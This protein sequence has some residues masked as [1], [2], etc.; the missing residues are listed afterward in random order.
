MGASICV[1]LLLLRREFV[2]FS[3]FLYPSNEIV[4]QATKTV[5]A[6]YQAGR[7]AGRQQERT[8]QISQPKVMSTPLLANILKILSQAVE[9]FP[10]ELLVH[11]RTY[12]HLYIIAPENV[13][14]LCKYHYIHG[15]VR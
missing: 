8:N 7:Q 5:G 2:P 12:T 13:F 14:N 9:K 4:K 10:L 6:A 15:K 3:L 11:T 1:V